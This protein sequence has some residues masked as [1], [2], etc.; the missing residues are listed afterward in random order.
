MHGNVEEPSTASLAD[1][2]EH[3]VP[4]GGARQNIR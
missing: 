4:A 1:I 2:I 3:F